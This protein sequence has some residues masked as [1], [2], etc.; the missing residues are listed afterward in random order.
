MSNLLEETRKLMPGRA[1]SN[2]SLTEQAVS[3]G[4]EK[5]H[6]R[7]EAKKVDEAKGEPV[8]WETLP[9]P[10]SLGTEYAARTTMGG[11]PVK[12]SV[13][14]ARPAPT[15][16]FFW[17]AYVG[18]PG[19]GQ[20]LDGSAT[21]VAKAKAKAESA[22]KK[23]IGKVAS[24]SVA[25]APGP[26]VMLETAGSYFDLGKR[27][28]EGATV[29]ALIGQTTRAPKKGVV[30]RVEQTYHG[31]H[32]SCDFEAD[33]KTYRVSSDVLFDHKPKKVQ[34]Q[35]V[36]G[37]VTVWED[38]AGAPGPFAISDEGSVR[39]EV[40]DLLDRVRSPRWEYPS[41]AL[42][43]EDLAEA[44][45]D[46]EGRYTLVRHKGTV[47]AKGQ[48]RD[49]WE[50]MYP[51]KSGRQAK[52]A[53][54]TQTSD[55]DD[56]Y[57]VEVGTLRPETLT[58]SFRSVGDA[59]RGAI[60]RWEKSHARGVTE[61]AEGWDAA[62][63]GLAKALRRA[64]YSEGDVEKTASS[65]ATTILQSK[66]V[67]EYLWGLPKHVR[68]ESFLRDLITLPLQKWLRA[69][70]GDE[71][72]E[73]AGLVDE[74]L[75]MLIPSARSDATT[76]RKHVRLAGVRESI[77]GSKKHM[78]YPSDYPPGYHQ[79][80]LGAERK[81]MA[82]PLY[83]AAET[84]LASDATIARYLKGLALATEKGNQEVQKE[85]L[86]KLPKAVRMKYVPVALLKALATP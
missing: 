86:G 6:E 28:E 85:F 81:S 62:S 57:E 7:V 73:M 35:D 48:N 77:A 61:S 32:F 55:E 45:E 47:H 42:P 40:E 38:V 18:E 33:G 44:A 23:L 41:W 20:G 3:A 58:Q 67:M 75:P 60:K 21:G 17:V 26:S 43:K 84:M 59:F 78:S 51:T 8:S 63:S 30:Q 25:G 70:D 22:A 66:A 79:A 13:F 36:Y 14:P 71:D 31:G 11:K 39:D 83:K 64:D 9:R 19:K 4:A 29:W 72:P 12:L 65:V 24:E 10:G 27:P 69:Q 34:K 5:A 82:E 68:S 2:W 16:K 37:D 80:V 46:T 76:V 1:R 49:W 53:T 15:D 54:I 50:V 52:I 74:V 56:P